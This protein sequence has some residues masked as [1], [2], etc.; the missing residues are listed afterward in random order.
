MPSEAAADNSSL[1]T[2]HAEVHRR[3]RHESASRNPQHPL[4]NL[5]EEQR[6]VERVKDTADVLVSMLRRLIQE[7]GAG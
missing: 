6:Q 1:T 7:R 2:V 3:Q 5:P 4:C